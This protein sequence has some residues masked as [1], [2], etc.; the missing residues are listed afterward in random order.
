MDDEA[1]AAAAAAVVSSSGPAQQTPAD[2]DGRRG[3][4]DQR[5]KSKLRELL[6]R[7]DLLRIAIDLTLSDHMSRKEIGKVTSQVQMLYGHNLRD[8]NPARLALTGLV[9]DSP[10]WREF[11]RR[12]SGF[13]DWMVDRTA[14]PYHEYFEGRDIV[15]LTPDSEE[16]LLEIDERVVR[17]LAMEVG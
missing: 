15:F 6:Q 7:D 4:P 5:T 10:T 12:T 8:P 16:P 13:D 1:T 11:E 17:L 14:Q 3:R 2:L 9:E